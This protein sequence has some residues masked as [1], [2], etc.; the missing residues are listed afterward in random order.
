MSYRSIRYD[1]GIPFYNQAFLAQ[2]APMGM[3]ES[4]QQPLLPSRRVEGVALVRVEK[5]EW[6]SSYLIHKF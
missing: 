4:P 6:I 2:L 1:K 3:N 5:G